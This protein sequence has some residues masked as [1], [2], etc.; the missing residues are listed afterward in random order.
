MGQRL[1]RKLLLIYYRLLGR[2]ET[3][4]RWLLE[5]R[6]EKRTEEKHSGPERFICGCGQL[7]VRGDRRCPRCGELHWLPWPLRRLG[8]WSG[9]SDPEQMVGTRLAAALCLFGYGIQFSY[10]EGNFWSPSVHPLELV[11]LGAVTP[12]AWSSLSLE[13]W[14]LFT[15]TLI[16]GNLMHIAFNLLALM[17]VGPLIERA[18]GSARF[19]FAWLIA[20]AGAIVL[21]RMIGFGDHLVIGASG[22]VFG[23]I[24][25]AMAYGHRIKTQAGL[26]IRN[27]MIEWTVLCTVFG[28]MIGQVA[29]S[30]HFG[31]LIAGIALSFLIPPPQSPRARMVTP[32][33]SGLSLVLILGLLYAASVYFVQTRESFELLMRR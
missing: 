17:Q 7:M 9:W 24:G 26:F 25:I 15:Y 18:F 22:A 3:Q 30:A 1:T 2:S 6:E 8:Q 33:L 27:K 20:G 5:R 32:L 16:H 11:L 21:P 29:H 13:P 19:L 10:G 14:R 28:L 4:A 12:E 31:G 23:L